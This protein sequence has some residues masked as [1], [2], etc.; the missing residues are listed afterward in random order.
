MRGAREGRMIRARVVVGAA[1]AA[2]LVSATSSRVA[3][4]DE[5]IRVA[6]P[7][8]AELPFDWA[9]FESLLRIELAEGGVTLEK[10]GTSTLFVDVA[11]CDASGATPVTLTFS[12]P[13]ARSRIVGLVDVDALVRPRVLAL[14]ASEFVSSSIATRSPSE[15][16][17]APVSPPSPHVDVPV[18]P[19]PSA[20]TPP[21]IAFP[22]L[23]AAPPATPG[24]STPRMRPFTA[25]LAFAA[26]VFPIDDTSFA[27]LEL[28]GSIRLTGMLRLRTA[29]LG[30]YARDD[31][32]LGTTHLAGGAGAIGLSL[33]ARGDVVGFDVGP[34]LDVGGLVFAAHAA[35]GAR[36]LSDEPAEPFVGLGLDAEVDLWPSAGFFVAL[37]I[38]G[39]GALVGA[40]GEVDGARA[41]GASGPFFGLR[42]GLGVAP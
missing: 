9:A 25:A 18:A 35:P 2:A 33:G 13:P 39:G 38:E 12:G 14:A 7:A 26:R 28:R 23:V 10:A 17:S 5:R 8:C 21:G 24:T 4:A 22:P 15:P 20:P 1:L 41:I 42:L 32:A 31:E 29:I 37:A 34:R 16:I 3:R 19:P 40:T 27:G 6:P 11:A 30:L 36:I